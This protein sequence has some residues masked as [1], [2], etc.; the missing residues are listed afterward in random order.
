MRVFLCLP[1]EWLTSVGE[2]K[3]EEEKNKGEINKNK[4][5]Q[6]K[7]KKQAKTKQKQKK[8]QEI[9]IFLWTHSIGCNQETK[10]MTFLIRTSKYVL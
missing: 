3:K 1:V 4:K 5:K 10:E 8:S 7:Q 6:K 2:K 9:T